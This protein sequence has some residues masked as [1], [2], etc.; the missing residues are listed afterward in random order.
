MS[1]VISTPL[2]TV[3]S[4]TCGPLVPSP[5]ILSVMPSGRKRRLSGRHNIEPP[6]RTRIVAVRRAPPETALVFQDVD[7]A[8]DLPLSGWAL[9][10]DYA[11]FDA[12]Q[13]RAHEPLGEAC[14]QVDVGDRVNRAAM[15]RVDSLWDI[16]SKFAA[17]GTITAP[18][19]KV[20]ARGARWALDMIR[21]QCEASQG[22][23]RDHHP[24][25]LCPLRLF[26][27][28]RARGQ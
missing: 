20:G 21:L 11:E 24:H 26:G 6:P 27:P 9:S 19:R 17:C 18:M 5:P 10:D 22:G 4:M 12:A 7:A 28:R 2:A 14:R 16:S 15:K 8:L 25:L 3:R 23:E 13:P 1:S